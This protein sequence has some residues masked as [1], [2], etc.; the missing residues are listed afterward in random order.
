MAA[1]LERLSASQASQTFSRHLKAPDV[2]E[3][4][5]RDNESNG[6]GIDPAMSHPWNT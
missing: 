4:D 3:P 6:K 5:T 1:A 2:F